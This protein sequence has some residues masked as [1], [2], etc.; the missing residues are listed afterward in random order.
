MSMTAGVPVRGIFEFDWDAELNRY[1]ERA[2]ATL[3]QHR[4]SEGRCLKCGS[5][6]PCPAECGA[7]FVLEL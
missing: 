3:A 4:S 2:V 5:P 1:R 7:E 6:T